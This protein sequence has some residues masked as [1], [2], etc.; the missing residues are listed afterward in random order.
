MIRTDYE[1][2]KRRPRKGYKCGILA[3][4]K[5]LQVLLVMLFNESL[6]RDRDVFDVA[7]LQGNATLPVM[8]LGFA[9]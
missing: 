1:T 9:R 3:V 7:F 4:L 8:M 2:Q 6:A 5:Q